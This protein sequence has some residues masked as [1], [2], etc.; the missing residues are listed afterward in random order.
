MRRVLRQLELWLFPGVPGDL[1]QPVPTRRGAGASGV[2]AEKSGGVAGSAVALVTGVDGASGVGSSGEAADES[3][4]MAM[5]G[6]CVREALRLGLPELAGCL[7][8]RWNPRMRT[9]AGRAWWPDRV[10]ELNGRLRDLDGGEVAWNTLKHELAH[11]VAYERAGRRRIAPHGNEWR[12]AC[13]DLGI[14]GESVCHALPLR[15]NRMKRKFSYG[16]PVCGESFER[17]RRIR[18]PVACLAC[19]RKFAGGRYDKRFRLR[20][21]VL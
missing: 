21:Q 14:A 10:I 9:T 11:L 6:W 12:K 19:C 2:D 5:R 8:V 15:G 3:W 13:A 16:C 20:E 1:P 18:R 17:V 7:V 4:M